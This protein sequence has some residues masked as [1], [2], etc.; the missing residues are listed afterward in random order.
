MGTAGDA[1][2]APLSILLVS[3]P[4]GAGT[5]RHVRDLANGLA[6]R[7]HEVTVACPAEGT[8][9]QELARD[10]V[11]VV[12]LQMHRE[13]RPL[14]DLRSFVKLVRLCRRLRPDVLHLHSSKAG[15]LGRI[16]GHLAGVPVVLFTP[17]CWSFQSTTGRKRGFYISLERFA[18][19]FCDMTIAVSEEEAREAQQLG[20][21][22]ADRVRVIHNGLSDAELA[23]PESG[24]RDIPFVSVGRLDEQ[25][26]YGYL[27]EAMAEL[28]LFEPDARLSIVGDGPLR[29]ELEAS[30][31]ALGLR[32]AVRFEG[33]DPDAGRYLRR[34]HVFVLS[35]L[36]EGLPYTILEAMAARLPVIASDVGGCRELVVNGET[37]LLVPAKDPA[38]L[39]QA[40]RTLWS[41]A[42]LRVRYGHAGH[43]Y[44]SRMFRLEDC[45]DDNAAVYQELLA[46]RS[47]QAREV[48]PVGLLGKAGVALAIVAALL[49]GGV[50]FDQVASRDKILAGV[51]VGAVEVGGLT[52]DEAAAKVRAL[53]SK[54]VTVT[55]LPASSG[56]P[57][58]GSDLDFDVTAALQKAYLVGRVGALPNRIGDRMTAARGAVS[59]PLAAADD[60]AVA[61]LLD[62]ARHELER[63]PVDAGFEIVNG[64]LKIS[65]GH[66]GV[67]VDEPGFLAML[68]VAA[69]S[70]RAGERTV[71]VPVKEVP[72]AVSK[73]AIAEVFSSA[74]EWTRADV[75]GEAQATSVTLTREQL[76]SLLT[77]RDGA[78]SV[79][80]TRVADALAGANLPG[81]APRDA[82]FEVRNGVVRIIDGAPGTQVDASATAAS[83]QKAL[84][85]GND[86][87]EIVLTTHEPDVTKGDLE[88][89]GIKRQ[90]SSYTTQFK[91]GQDGRDVNIALASSAFRG[92]VLGIGETF[93][94]NAETGPRNKGTG[95][96][97][98]LIF[99]NGKVVPGVGGG[100]CQVS[101]TTYQAALRADL[102]I[103]DRQSHSMAVSYVDPGLD[104]TTYYP[105]VDLK[106]QNTT[107]G[108][109]LMWSEIRGNKLTVSVYGSSQPPDVG[110]QTIVKKTIRQGERT[111]SD[112]S[113]AKGQRVVA[114]AGV[115]GYVVT[116]YRLVREGGRI[117]RKELLATDVY[118]PRDA[119]IR[120]GD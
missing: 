53:A 77:V 36:W 66:P 34:A 45:V 70:G 21:L 59:L 20:V 101:T 116:S 38:A 11:T 42:A 112:P 104:A 52:I 14:A 102:R 13:I 60:G 117:V 85:S 12:E 7:G 113:L 17:H 6:R 22:T 50:V 78:L 49:V 75:T 31:A 3:Q 10:G 1:A 100:V 111:V 107:S 24:D 95:Y 106:F 61:D 94:L 110:V 18:S 57:V 46:S 103:I 91:L 44:A 118:R 108:P 93:S 28:V 47:L 23:Q 99:S 105:I 16:A 41:D 2:P 96:R 84:A 69:T 15:F 54:P 90:L 8:L 120:V 79:S 68:G 55:V 65:G 9:P 109:I 58:P 86:R 33:E 4:T 71:Q 25:K 56:I 32:D 98:S 87:F 19:R 76:A 48:R 81:S 27:L 5:A 89:L 62:G 115:P 72:A 64:E 63:A 67:T 73:D 74:A 97:E 80:D 114:S 83:L 40:M 35:S 43:A 82:K 30:A 119:V 37:G 29:A 88:K 92:K 39:A 26:G 51:Q